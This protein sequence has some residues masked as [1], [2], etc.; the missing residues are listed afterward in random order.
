LRM[1]AAQATTINIGSGNTLTTGGILVTAAVGNNLTQITG[2]TLTGPVNQDLVIIQ[3][4]TANGLTI[5]STIADNGVPAGL[6]KS[7]AGAL[8]LSGT[9]GCDPRHAPK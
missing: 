7:G 6:T 8:T 2:G 3:N 5:S 1:N 4:N 9:N